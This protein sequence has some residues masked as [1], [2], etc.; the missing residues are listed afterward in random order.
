[1]TVVAQGCQQGTSKLQSKCGPKAVLEPSPAS[2][3]SLA[4]H[5]V[6]CY[7]V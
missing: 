1:M 6:L 5:E 4:A 3:S 2:N 7:R